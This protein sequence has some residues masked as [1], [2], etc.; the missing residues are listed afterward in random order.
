MRTTNPNPSA[1]GGYGTVVETIDVQASPRSPR[2]LPHSLDRSE[3]HGHDASSGKGSSD[4]S[5]SSG[6][7]DIL[8]GLDSDGERKQS[9]M[10]PQRSPV[11]GLRHMP[12]PTIEEPQGIEVGGMRST[13]AKHIKIRSGEVVRTRQEPESKDDRSRSK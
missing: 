10:A 2:G 7:E 1:A 3:R 4:R 6:D 8:E 5:P 13:T 11:P 9:S 12:Q